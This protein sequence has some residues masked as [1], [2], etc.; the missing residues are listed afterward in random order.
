MERASYITLSLARFDT[1]RE[2]GRL[3][4]SD[5]KSMF[6]RVGAD[7]RAAGT[8]ASTRTAYKFCAIA[9]HEDLESAEAYY[10]SRADTCGWFGDAK[11]VWSALLRPVRHVGEVN[12]LSKDEPGLVFHCPAE[13]VPVG[14]LIV[15]TSA[16]FNRE[17]DWLERATKFGE[18]VSAVRM[19]MT[20]LPGLISQQSFFLD[21]ADGIT[22]TMWKDF[23]AV[24]GFAYGPGVHKDN[25]MVQKAGE[26]ADRTSF[27]RCV[28]EQSE[29]VWHGT[30]PFK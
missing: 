20:G 3:T 9:L 5:A 23:S 29:G 16:G 15:I 4:D 30:E 27:T 26:F 14:P 17:G 7:C 11:E 28:I 8:A 12:F 21:D 10:A 24:R 25:M 13:A 6:S 1:R 18:G 22:V 2:A 19:G